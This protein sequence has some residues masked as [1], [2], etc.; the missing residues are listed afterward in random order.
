MHFILI[1]QGLKFKAQRNTVRRFGLAATGSNNTSVI[2]VYR[3]LEGRTKQ[4]L[5]L[6]SAAPEVIC[7]ITRIWCMSIWFWNEFTKNN[8]LISLGKQTILLSASLSTGTWGKGHCERRCRRR[9]KQ[10]QKSRITVIFQSHVFLPNSPPQ[11]IITGGLH[12]DCM[13]RNGGVRPFPLTNQQRSMPEFPSDGDSAQWRKQQGRWERN[14]GRALFQLELLLR[15]Q[16]KKDDVILCSF[17]K[18]QYGANKK[19]TFFCGSQ[20]KIFWKMSQSL[21]QYVSCICSILF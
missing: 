20:K 4:S 5:W 15:H 17:S 21:L 14:R 8:E 3:I 2:S 7:F 13:L 1:F 9:K 18:L 6:C 12:A 10:T 19:L 11:N 16:F